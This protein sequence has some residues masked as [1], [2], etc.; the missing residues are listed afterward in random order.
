M[1][2]QPNRGADALD[3]SATATNTHTELLPVL[4]QMLKAIET[5]ATEILEQNVTQW[6]ELNESDAGKR[7]ETACDAL[8]DRII[9]LLTPVSGQYRA[10]DDA[11]VVALAARVLADCV[12]A[13]NRANQ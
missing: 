2:T 8:A 11:Y 4:Q 12:V 1:H 9:D 7:A 5:V 13:E 3:A 6:D 10:V